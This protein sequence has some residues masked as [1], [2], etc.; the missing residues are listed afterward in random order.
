M[1]QKLRID[2]QAI[3]ADIRSGMGD[4]PIMEKYGLSPRLYRRIL[5]TLRANRSATFA[6]IEGRMK[7]CGMRKNGEEKRSATRNYIL[8]EM[9][10]YNANEPESIGTLNDISEAGLQVSGMDVEVDDL[11]TLMIRSDG[12]HVHSPFTL[13]AICR[14]VDGKK[15]TGVLMAGF[16]ITCILGRGDRE[17]QK[18]VDELAV[19][20]SPRS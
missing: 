13:D 20:D 8:Y 17:L 12:F 9:P 7:A 15:D 3:L 16:E 19:P 11:V 18:L 14:W 4:V 6:D 5:E 1:R 10:V 2:S